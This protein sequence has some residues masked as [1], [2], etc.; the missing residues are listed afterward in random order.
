LDD[1]G[2]HLLQIVRSDMSV[3]AAST[4]GARILSSYPGSQDLHC[5]GLGVKVVHGLLVYNRV[6]TTRQLRH[7]V[8]G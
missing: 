6:D 8:G 7:F 4:A 5:G 3:F 1:G 2:N